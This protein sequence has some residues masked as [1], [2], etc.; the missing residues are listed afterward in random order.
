MTPVLLACRR[1]DRWMG[2]WMHGQTDRWEDGPFTQMGNTGREPD[3]E[4]S[5]EV[6]MRL[7]K[8]GKACEFN[9]GAY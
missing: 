4:G 7:A 5:S 1:M 2:G 8:A 3:L 9:L 6:G